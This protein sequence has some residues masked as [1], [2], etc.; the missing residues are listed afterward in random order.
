MALLAGV[1]VLAVLQ[2]LRPAGPDGVM[3]V[4]A[5]RDL[6]AGT[7]LQSDDLDLLLLPRAALPAGTFHSPDQVHGS[8]LTHPI[9][10]RQ[11]VVPGL[12]AEGGWGLGPDRLAVGVRLADPLLAAQLR[13][14]DRVLLLGSS[15]GAEQMA[16]LTP[17][18]TVLAVERAPSGGL[19]SGTSADEPLLVFS[20]PREVGTLVIDASTRG[21]LTAAWG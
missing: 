10:A 5:A 13:A 16:V 8:R 4:V 9:A 14:G 1:L 7:E 2:A 17:E 15:A 21:T 6:P 12:L 11:P 19:L 3:V 18:A 20:V